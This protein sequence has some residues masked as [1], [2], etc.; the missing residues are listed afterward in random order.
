MGR[1]AGEDPQLAQIVCAGNI[2]G[3]GTVRKERGCT[4]LQTGTGVYT[5]DIPPVN[6]DLLPAVAGQ[7]NLSG[8]I[9]A[10][11]LVTELQT[12]GGVAEFF[13]QVENTSDIQKTISIINAA[14]AAA[15]DDFEFIFKRSM[16]ASSN[17]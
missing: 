6:A 8:G 12:T 17:P 9:P 1:G 5:V 16:F 2:Q 11:E 10:A 4:V 14:D 3:D 7:G 15:D 13:I